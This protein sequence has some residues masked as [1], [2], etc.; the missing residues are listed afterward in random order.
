MISV[1]VTNFCDS[2]LCVASTTG[3]A[4]PILQLEELEKVGCTDVC[5]YWYS[6]TKQSTCSSLVATSFSMK[7]TTANEMSERCHPPV[8][9]PNLDD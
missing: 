2:Y 6:R 9:N 1:V 7:K 3:R 5:F 4:T 8:Y